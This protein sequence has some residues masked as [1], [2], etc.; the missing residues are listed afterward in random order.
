[1]DTGSCVLPLCWYCSFY[2]TRYVL[3][4]PS[5]RMSARDLEKFMNL[6]GSIC[7]EFK[8]EIRI[9]NRKVQ[10]GRQISFFFS[11]HCNPAYKKLLEHPSKPLWLPIKRS[12]LSKIDLTTDV[13][14]HL[15]NILRFLDYFRQKYSRPLF[16]DARMKRSVWW[17]RMGFAF[18]RRDQLL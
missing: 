14:L 9:R 10:W 12:I 15:K 1:M 7:A 5:L 18:K 16:K 6:Q 13:F 3:R 2:S 8:E 17:F 11:M 4:M